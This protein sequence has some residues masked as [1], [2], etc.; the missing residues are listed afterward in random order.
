MRKDFPKLGEVVSQTLHRFALVSKFS[1]RNTKRRDIN[2][3]FDLSI[4]IY[5][6][7]VVLSDEPLI[8]YPSY[9]K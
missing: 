1:V 9:R 6:H 3:V 2:L 4:S 8:S 7:F 5:E